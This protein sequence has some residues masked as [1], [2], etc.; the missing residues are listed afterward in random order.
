MEY[1]HDAKN[2][3]SCSPRPNVKKHV[4]GHQ[5]VAHTISSKE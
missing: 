4:D 1:S 5:I 2:N 3:I